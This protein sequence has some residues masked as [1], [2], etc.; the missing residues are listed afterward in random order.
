MC[1]IS[2]NELHNLISSLMNCMR[3]H[4]AEFLAWDL[5]HYPSVVRTFCPLGHPRGHTAVRSAVRYVFFHS[6]LYIIVVWTCLMGIPN[7]LSH[8]V[9]Y[10]A[11]SFFLLIIS[12]VLL[13]VVGYAWIADCYLLV[14]ICSNFLI[15]QISEQ[16]KAETVSKVCEIVK[17]QLA[18]PDG[19]EVTGESKFAALGADSLD[20][21][22]RDLLK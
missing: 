8:F 17:K 19:S 3:R 11:C 1:L 9:L 14:C 6:I 16:A 20:T 13:L 18:L 5:S 21:V 12:C 15:V 22:C 7:D 4:R 10:I 2:S